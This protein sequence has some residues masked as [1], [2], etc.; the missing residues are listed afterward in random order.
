MNKPVSLE[1]KFKSILSTSIDLA[2]CRRVS[3]PHIKAVEGSYG[4]PFEM[5]RVLTENISALSIE[6]LRE[7]YK[8][9][10]QIKESSS[11]EVNI[12]GAEEVMSKC[13]F[14]ARSL[15]AEVSK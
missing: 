15:T 8:Y 4:N 6:E 14:V 7:L 13:R 3:G 10:K 9:A 12:L 2:K 1:E 11:Y 5:N